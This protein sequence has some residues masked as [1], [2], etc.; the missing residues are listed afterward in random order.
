MASRK[1]PHTEAHS[2][3]SEL[4]LLLQLCGPDAPEVLD[5]VRGILKLDKKSG[6]EVLACLIVRQINPAHVFTE[7]QEAAMR[8]LSEDTL[9]DYKAA[10]DLPFIMGERDAPER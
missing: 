1:K 6:K 5:T 10:K 9:R 3:L 2:G 4:G 8:G 7:A